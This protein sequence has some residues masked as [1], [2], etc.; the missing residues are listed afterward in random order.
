MQLMSPLFYPTPCWPKLWQEGCGSAA[1]LFQP[2][3]SPS[4]ALSG[5]ACP[6][7]YQQDFSIMHSPLSG[8][9]R[10]ILFRIAGFCESFL[11]CVPIPKKGITQLTPLRVLGGLCLGG[12]HEQPG[13]CRSSTSKGWLIQ[14]YHPLNLKYET[15]EI[16][17]MQLFTMVCIFTESQN[18]W[19]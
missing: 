7:V 13:I 11:S 5:T 9:L 17:Q 15:Y 3:Y 16:E 2:S 8:R 14:P 18:S 1:L 4:P 10:P 19:R 6:S 12:S